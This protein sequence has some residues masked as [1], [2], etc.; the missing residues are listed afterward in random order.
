MFCVLSSSIK[1]LS[2]SLD[3]FT[4]FNFFIVLRKMYLIPTLRVYCRKETRSYLY[5]SPTKINLAK[6]KI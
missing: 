4:F 5:I 2:K 1:N 6:Q 3:F